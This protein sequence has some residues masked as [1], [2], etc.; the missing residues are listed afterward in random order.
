[1]KSIET[2]RL[3]IRP[4]TIDDLDD[5]HAIVDLD[6][7]VQLA[8]HSSSLREREEHLR[9]YIGGYRLNP[10]FGFRAVVLKE[11][12]RL[13]GRVGVST[14]LASFI[15]LEAEQDDPFNALEAEIA[16]D[17]SSE[18]W[19]H[20]YATEAAGA[21]VKVAFEEMK[22]I[23]IVSVTDADN[24]R[25]ISVMRK[26]GMRTEKN[27]HHDWPGGIAGILDNTRAG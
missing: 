11:T 15:A 14:Y 22:L 9:Y 18:H 8:E 2:D 1:M 25:S 12:G 16:W 4:F 19:G 13:I 10:G 3:L 5:L 7:K 20:G 6:P 17:L 24:H 27:L 21:M 23:R 26:L